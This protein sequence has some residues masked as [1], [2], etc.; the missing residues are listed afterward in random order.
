M[1]TRV[2]RN[3]L[4]RYST[5]QIL[6]HLF[7]VAAKLKH[8][9]AHDKSILTVMQRTCF[10]RHFWYG[11]CFQQRHNPAANG[12]KRVCLACTVRLSKPALVSWLAGLSDDRKSGAHKAIV[13]I[14]L[15]CAPP[16]RFQLCFASEA[17][18]IPPCQLLKSEMNKRGSH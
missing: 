14:P 17:T 18:P 9:N 15:Y 6:L 4:L 3:P 11:K 8:R 10:P 7:S 16:C 13:A 5:T 12:M 1:I 2:I